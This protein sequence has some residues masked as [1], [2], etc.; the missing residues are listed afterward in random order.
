MRAL[1]TTGSVAGAANY[2][3]GLAA[4]SFRS[5]Y[6]T[7]VLPKAPVP[8]EERY[9]C[10]SSW[11]EPSRKIFMPVQQRAP[12]R[13]IGTMSYPEGGSGGQGRA[14]QAA[15]GERRQGR[16]TPGGTPEHS[17]SRVGTEAQRVMKLEE[18]KKARDERMKL[19]RAAIE[20]R[21]RR[22]AW[23]P[24]ARDGPD[25]PVQAARRKRRGRRG[26]TPACRRCPS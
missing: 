7:C 2:N 13:R 14:L 15:S 1:G 18:L 12:V 8:V 16:W 11:V 20:D 3:S 19:M 6:P 23:W 17:R 24:S 4:H 5:A 26:M 9:L 10:D 22:L 25:E 21:S